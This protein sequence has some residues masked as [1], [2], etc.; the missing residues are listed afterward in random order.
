MCNKLGHLS[1]EWKINAGIGD[2]D[3]IL[4]KDKSKDI[5]STYVRALC[6]ILPQKSETHRT[7]L[8]AE[9]NIIYYPGEF[10]TPTSD[11]NTMKLNVNSFISDIKYRYMCTDVKYF[12]LNN[13]MYR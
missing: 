11:L 4:H 13:H 9:G 8:I 12:Y 6:D 10:I 7:S 5:K 1:Q 2:I 3:F